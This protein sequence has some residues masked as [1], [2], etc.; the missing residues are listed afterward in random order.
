M[1]LLCYLLVY[2]IVGGL[3]FAL[4]VGFLVWVGFVIL[5]GFLF[6]VD[7]FLGWMGLVFDLI[8]V[9][10]LFVKFLFGLMM[11]LRFSLL[12]LFGYCL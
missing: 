3:W 2:F 7:L 6:A 9:C 4:L 8:A 1:C 12:V 11:W 10:C 5:G